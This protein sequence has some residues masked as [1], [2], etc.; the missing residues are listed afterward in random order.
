MGKIY[1]GGIYVMP[2]D[3]KPKAGGNWQP[4]NIFT[5]EERDQMLSDYDGLKTED[6]IIERRFFPI[7][8]NG[9]ERLFSKSMDTDRIM[10]Q[11]ENLT[12]SIKV[13]I[14]WMEYDKKRIDLTSFDYF[15]FDDNLWNGDNP[16]SIPN[17]IIKSIGQIIV[18]S[19]GMKTDAN[20]VVS[21][22]L[23]VNNA[24]CTLVNNPETG[25][26]DPPGSGVQ[27]PNH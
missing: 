13:N 17:G 19:I 15:I 25:G 7:S 8:K 2:K 10:L 6:E 18:A 26:G 24:M 1:Q 16:P 21:H 9:I 11:V 5:P 4:D 12:D 20:G 27:I 22:F 3:V 14:E 23:I